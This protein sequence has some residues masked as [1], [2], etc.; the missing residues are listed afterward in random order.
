MNHVMFDLV[1]HHLYCEICDSKQKVD[2]P[3][4]LDAFQKTAKDFKKRHR[5]CQPHHKGAMEKLQTAKRKKKPI[6]EP[7]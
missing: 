6:K 5:M 1:T 4:S 2:F 3:T 7:R